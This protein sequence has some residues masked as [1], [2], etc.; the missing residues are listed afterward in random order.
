METT[1]RE[2]QGLGQKRGSVFHVPK[3]IQPMPWVTNSEERW[4]QCML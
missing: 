2:I 3:L 1:G 4:A